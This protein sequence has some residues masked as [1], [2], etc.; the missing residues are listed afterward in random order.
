MRKCEDE[1][2]NDSRKLKKST[3]RPIFSIF[4]IDWERGYLDSQRIFLS[5]WLL[6][7]TG[8]KFPIKWT[9]PEAINF[10]TFSIKS[11]VWSFGILLTEIVTFGRI[12]YPGRRRQL[13]FSV[14]EV[15]AAFLIYFIFLTSG[16]T[17]PEVIRSLDRSYRMPCPEG[18]PAELYDVMMM[19]WKQ[20]AEE[21]PTFEFLQTT[22]NDFFIATEGQYEM[23]P[24][25]RQKKRPEE[26]LKGLLVQTESYLNGQF[27]GHELRECKTLTCLLLFLPKCWWKWSRH[28]YNTF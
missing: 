13:H 19:C 20:K 16:M 23:Q 10:G 15:L 21:R 26:N 24:W 6:S 18:C 8:A 1:G 11:D 17:N 2:L 3:E 7:N 22:L 12:P 27:S 28:L 5:K 4:N 9:A 14:H 25:G